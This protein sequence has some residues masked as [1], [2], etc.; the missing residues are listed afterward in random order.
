MTV[1]RQVQGNFLGVWRVHL[2]IINNS[3][4]QDLVPNRPNS[5][6]IHWHVLLSLRSSVRQSRIRSVVPTVLVGSILYLS[7]QATSEGV[8]L[9]KF[10]NLNFWHFFQ[11]CNFVLF[12]LG[13]SCES[14]VW[15]IMGR[16]G[17][18]QNAGILGVL[19]LN[20]QLQAKSKNNSNVLIFLPLLSCE[21]HNQNPADVGKIGIYHLPERS[22]TYFIS[23]HIFYWTDLTAT[24][25]Y[26]QVRTPVLIR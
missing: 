4:C 24:I 19:G 22:Q 16:R 11:I 10:Q 14:L 3:P 13:I 15:V 26:R 25:S 12:W 21:H 20:W 1:N 17:V 9:V 18:S 6:L 23:I 2:T 8:S 7:Y 5:A